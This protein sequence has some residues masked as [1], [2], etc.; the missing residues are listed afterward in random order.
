MPAF[1]HDINQNLLHSLDYVILL[2]QCTETNEYEH[3]RHV[4]TATLSC[5]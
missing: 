1:L 3:P 2:A 4:I 5:G